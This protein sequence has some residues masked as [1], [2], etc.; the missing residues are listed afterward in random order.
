RVWAALAFGATPLPIYWPLLANLRAHYGAHL[1]NHYAFT[2]LPSTYGAFFL[3]DSAFGAA[4][5]VLAVAGV[6]GSHLLLRPGA[7]SEGKVR[8]A[9]VAEGTLLLALVSLPII[10]FAVVKSMHG[11]MRD[12]H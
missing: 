9:D 11:A 1:W 7:P 4:V 12:A 5:F 2:T 3:T 10:T 6:I 8:D